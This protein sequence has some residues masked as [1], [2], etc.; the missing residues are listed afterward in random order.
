MATSNPCNNP[1]PQNTA[2]VS[3]CACESAASNLASA[4]N[5][6]QQA[7]QY[8]E[9]ENSLY[10]NEENTYTANLQNWQ[11]SHDAFQSNLQGKRQNGNCIAAGFCPNSN[12]ASGWQNDGSVSGTQ[13]N[14]QICAG[15]LCGNTGCQVQCKLSDDSVNSEMNQWLSQNP[16]PKIPSKP[17]LNNPNPPSANIQCC[18][19]GISN[20]S[21]NN[22]N[23]SNIQQQCSQN[24][25]KNIS[26]AI[27][28]A[29]E[30][31]LALLTEDYTSVEK[32]IIAEEQKI[33]AEEQLKSTEF[34][35]S[36][37]W[38]LS[39][40]LISICLIIYVI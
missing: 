34:I 10:T 20:V 11:K 14:C 37:V 38:L 24:I 19:I 29:E 36:I 32:E 22:V 3:A 40:L 18:N 8:N 30:K 16:A 15:K 12:C 23:I 5:Q 1:D 39:L 7:I 35:I 28:A 26:A 2:L 9:S 17:V 25:S 21:G 6:Y 27:I 33:I 31:K 4:V 13:S